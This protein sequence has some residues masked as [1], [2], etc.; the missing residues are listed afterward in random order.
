MSNTV[1]DKKRILVIGA[2]L[3]ALIGVVT[4]VAISSGEKSQQSSAGNREPLKYVELINLG[5]SLGLNQL[6]AATKSNLEQMIR[7]GTLSCEP[8]EGGSDKLELKSVR[9][10]GSADAFVFCIY[11]S[12]VNG[13]ES[14]DITMYNVSRKLELFS[15]FS[16]SSSSERSGANRVLSKYGIS[17]A[18]ELV[19]IKRI[20][21]R[22]RT[23]KGKNTCTAIYER[24]RI[25][26][27]SNRFSLESKSNTGVFN[28]NA[29]S[30]DSE[31]TKL[32]DGI[33]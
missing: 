5:Q 10:E 13:E 21:V 33:R 25:D 8:F 28:C 15:Y 22:S 18:N 6:D 20:S 27:E 14:D 16:D 2:A 4:M 26:K 7:D 30:D 19:D 32:F 11:R 17:S 24:V 3:L 29:L 1:S 31:M 12:L 23:F 9:I